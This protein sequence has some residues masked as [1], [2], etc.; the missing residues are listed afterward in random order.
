GR[1]L[2]APNRRG[3]SKA[4]RDRQPLRRSSHRRNVVGGGEWRS[5]LPLLF[6]GLLALQAQQ[7]L[8][9][10]A[11]SL[12]PLF[13]LAIVFNGLANLWHLAGTQA[14]LAGL[15]ARIAHVEDPER[16]ALTTGALLASRRVTD[17]A[18]EKRAA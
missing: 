8:I 3:A 16:M 10:F 7:E 13:E 14:N 12:Q 17:G 5:R 15:S 2:P 4:P 9:Q 6:F 1:H 11:D 18:L